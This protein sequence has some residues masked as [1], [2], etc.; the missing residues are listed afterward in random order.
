MWASREA[1]GT[2]DVHQMPGVECA[3]LLAQE[4][5]PFFA[6]RERIE[7]GIKHRDVGGI[8]VW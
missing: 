2:D 7:D 5:L 6:D 1:I 4:S 8:A 3:Q